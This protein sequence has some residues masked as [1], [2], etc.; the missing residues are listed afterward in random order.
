MVLEVQAPKMVARG[1]SSSRA[2]WHS[3]G[4][5]AAIFG[6]DYDS[7]CTWQAANNQQASAAVPML[8]EGCSIMA[9]GSAEDRRPQCRGNCFQ[10]HP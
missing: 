8:L 7:N 9:V 4:I 6:E 3:R 10:L 5:A 2:L 1:T